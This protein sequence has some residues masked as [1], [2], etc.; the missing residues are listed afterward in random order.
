MWLGI[1]AKIIKIFLRC[2]NV[3]RKRL[4]YANIAELLTSQDYCL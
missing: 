2:I 3:T 1:R 4:I